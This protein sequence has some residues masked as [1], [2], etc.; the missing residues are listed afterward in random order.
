MTQCVLLFCW[1]L[2]ILLCVFYVKARMAF[3][4]FVALPSSDDMYNRIVNYTQ[5]H[6]YLNV[7]ILNCN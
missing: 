4:E 7:L 1:A 3:Q 6:I 2:S 5:T